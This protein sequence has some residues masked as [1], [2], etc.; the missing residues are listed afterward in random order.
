M[1]DEAFRNKLQKASSA[2]E[3]C[4]LFVNKENE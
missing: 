1:L 2:K 4:E 3:V